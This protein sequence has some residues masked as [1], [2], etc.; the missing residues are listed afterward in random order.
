M[1]SYKHIVHI[2]SKDETVNRNTQVNGVFNCLAGFLM[3][4]P[5]GRQGLLPWG[6]F[7]GFP[8]TFTSYCTLSV[9][10]TIPNSH[11]C[12][13]VQFIS[14][15]GKGCKLELKPNSNLQSELPCLNRL[16]CD[17]SI[18]FKLNF[19]IHDATHTCSKT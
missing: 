10:F 14:S 6:G 5:E 18:L 19:R 4:L 3:L 2:I 16:D 8:V 11:G 1:Q 12:A 13:L 15:I 9:S 7:P 17:Y